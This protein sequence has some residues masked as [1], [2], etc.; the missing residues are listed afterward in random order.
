MKVLP[1]RTYSAA[2]HQ[3]RHVP[4]EGA[5]RADVCLEVVDLSTGSISAKVITSLRFGPQSSVSVTFNQ[6]PNAP[7]I[8]TGRVDLPEA[9]TEAFLRVEI[10]GGGKPRMS[11]DLLPLVG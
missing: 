2:S 10:S 11:G 8:Y 1:L 9:T 7:G 6:T 5:A 4:C 3:T